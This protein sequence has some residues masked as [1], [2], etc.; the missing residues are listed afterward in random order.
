[1]KKLKNITRAIIISIILILVSYPLIGKLYF[2]NE[3]KNFL[4]EKGCEGSCIKNIKV[5]HSYLNLILSYDEW[6]IL[7]EFKTEPDINYSFT[8][9]N[10]EIL[11]RSVADSRKTKEE[12]KI[13]EDKYHNGELWR[14]EYNFEAIIIEISNDFI[15][16]EVTGDG[17]LAKEVIVITDTQYKESFSNFKLGD[18]ITVFHDGLILESYPAQLTEVY[19]IVLKQE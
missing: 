4:Q 8:P 7:V 15:L 9:K 6:S 1:M 12:L 10:G 11:F 14:T 19:S 5:H 2:K 16:I 18:I 3:T 13:L 17:N